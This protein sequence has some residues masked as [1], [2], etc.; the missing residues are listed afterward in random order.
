MQVEESCAK[1]MQLEKAKR[2]SGLARIGF[3]W[4]GLGLECLGW[5]PKK[6]KINK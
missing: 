5:A 3:E 4:C 6:M 2:P 1:T